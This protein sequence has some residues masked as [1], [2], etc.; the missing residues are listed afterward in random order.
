[1]K[2]AVYINNDQVSILAGKKYL[3]FSL[4]QGSVSNGV[5]INR[6]AILQVLRDNRRLLMRPLV[7]LN[8]SNAILKVAEHP[9]MSKSQ[10]RSYLQQESG[11]PPIGDLGEEIRQ[12]K[13]P[14]GRRSYFQGV[15]KDLLESYISLFREAGISLGGVLTLQL[16]AEDFLA[17][18]KALNGQTCFLEI[19]EGENLLSILFD[20]GAYVLTDRSRLLGEPGS[21]AW[22]EELTQKISYLVQF[23]RSRKSANPLTAIY[24]S[25][26]QKDVLD[27]LRSRFPSLLLEDAGKAEGIPSQE[28]NPLPCLMGL[29]AKGG[30][31]ILRSS[32]KKKRKLSTREFLLL[33]AAFSLL[34]AA[35]G[36]LFTRNRTLSLEEENRALREEIS[37]SREGD[38]LEELLSKQS[39]LARIPRI[40]EELEAARGEGAP[41][42]ALT[43]DTLLLLI[44]KAGNDVLL[45]RVEGEGE[46][47]TVILQG[48]GTSEFSASRYVGALK[49]TGLFSQVEYSGYESSRKGEYSFLAVC[50]LK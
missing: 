24:F 35:G 13:I 16:A 7:L 30:K 39:L 21:P 45:E 4:P 32:R 28:G 41:F 5:L 8:S 15:P 47:G 48:V 49:D 6:E 36:Y 50:T 23:D 2:T 3:E 38:K 44:Q 26:F 43:R 27:F 33:A 1:M 42:E 34:V 14:G 9:A 18:S 40:L 10:F 19:L 17:S 31:E 11:L 12:V 20:Q 46:T 37:S 29:A 22:E 25:G